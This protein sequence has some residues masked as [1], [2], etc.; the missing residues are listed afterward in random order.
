MAKL[1]EHPIIDY[2]V[3]MGEASLIKEK[4]TTRVLLFCDSDYTCLVPPGGSCLTK[5]PHLIDYIF[6]KGII[7]AYYMNDDIH[8]S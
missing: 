2:Q 6:E 7:C 3:L 5:W 1:F 8:I 4:N